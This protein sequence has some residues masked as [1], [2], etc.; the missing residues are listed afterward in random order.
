ML[1]YLELELFSYLFVWCPSPGCLAYFWQDRVG[2]V[3]DDG[4]FYSRLIF[5]ASVM[6]VSGWYFEMVRDCFPLILFQF[7]RHLSCY[8]SCHKLVVLYVYG[9][10]NG[11]IIPG[12]L[13]SNGR[14]IHWRVNWKECGRKHCDLFEVVLWNLLGGSGEDHH[15][16][17]I[18]C[19]CQD[20]NQAV[21]ECKWY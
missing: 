17:R 16:L 15:T 11:V 3:L 12:R 19:S 7:T 8:I 20:S 5:S 2:W 14:K 1:Y 21:C 9:L 13:T 10:F 18:M 4:I 6:S